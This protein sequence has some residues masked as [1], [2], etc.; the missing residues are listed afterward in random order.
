MVDNTNTTQTEFNGNIS[1]LM[2]HHECIQSYYRARTEMNLVAMYNEFLNV[3]S[4]IVPEMSDDEYDTWQQ[5]KK[6][7]NGFYHT[8]VRIHQ[9]KTDITIQ[10][11]EI[12]GTFAIQLQDLFE[13][14]MRMSKKKG[15]L[16][17][18]SDSFGDLLQ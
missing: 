18:N 8:V 11:R 1:C 6:S 4:D 3:V 13:K 7:F 16:Q 9:K 15:M 12:L 5:D 17:R 2:R 14:Y 10:K